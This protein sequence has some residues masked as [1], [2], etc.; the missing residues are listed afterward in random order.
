MFVALFQARNPNA[1]YKRLYEKRC[2]A[3]DGGNRIVS[4][5]NRK[6]FRDSCVRTSHGGYVP[7]FACSRLFF[8]Y[9]AGTSDRWCVDSTFAT[10]PIGYTQMLAMGVEF[11]ASALPIFLVSSHMFVDQRRACSGADNEGR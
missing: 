3:N 1:S 6:N 11:G 2:V 9:R 7:T 4:K 5:D 8:L 10:C